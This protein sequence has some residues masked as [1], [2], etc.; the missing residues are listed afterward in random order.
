MNLIA[1]IINRGTQLS[2]I[3]K[4]LTLSQQRGRGFD[5]FSFMAFRNMFGN[6]RLLNPRLP[7]TLCQRRSAFTSTLNSDASVNGFADL[8]SLNLT[9]LQR[10]N[11]TEIET[12]RQACQEEGFFYLD[13]E[14]VGNGQM[15]RDWESIQSLM[16]PWFSR[17][18]HEKM[19][20]H[21][22]TLLHGQVTDIPC[23]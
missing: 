1:F 15:V 22:G 16:G 2:T 18:L 11:V 3:F 10:G 19:A 20:Y 13:L 8:K 9:R 12:L 21:C 6:V 14:R 23:I 17:P 5:T 4:L 7:V